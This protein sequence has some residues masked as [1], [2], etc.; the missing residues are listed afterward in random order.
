MI[1]SIQGASRDGTFWEELLDLLERRLVDFGD[2][3]FG[4]TNCGLGDFLISGL[5]GRGGFLYVFSRAASSCSS[6]LLADRRVARPDRGL[7]DSTGG[8]LKSVDDRSFSV[9]STG[10][11]LIS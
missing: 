2:S 4:T 11:S 6:G 7:G 8:A 10:T 9:L 3:L 1:V 5:G